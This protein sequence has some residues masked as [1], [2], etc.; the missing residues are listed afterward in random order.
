MSKSVTPA[1]NRLLSGMV[2]PVDVEATMQKPTAVKIGASLAL[3]AGALFSAPLYA[4]PKLQAQVTLTV[5]GRTGNMYAEYRLSSPVKSLKL[6]REA[7]TAR[8]EMWTPMTKGVK[9]D[10][11]S[12]VS[13]S[14][15]SF[16]HFI[17]RINPYSKLVD[18]NYA[19]MQRFSD[20]S[21][22]LFT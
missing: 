15:A 19:V 16:D 4:A 22:S 14:G 5:T 11:A 13:T 1:G 21:V 3:V 17:L 9:V 7:G 8:E 10:H 6:A 12:I 18:Q 2:L 20:G